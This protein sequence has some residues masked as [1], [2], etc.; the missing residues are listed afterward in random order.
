MILRLINL[1]RYRGEFKLIHTAQNWHNRRRWTSRCWCCS[2][3][4]VTLC[5][6]FTTRILN[7]MVIN[8][9]YLIISTSYRDKN[10]IFIG[11]LHRS[12]TSMVTKLIATSPIASMH[13]L[14]FVSEDEGQHIQTVYKAGQ[15]FG[16]PGSFGFNKNCYLNERSQLLTPYRKFKIV[17]EWNRYWDSSKEF[18]IEKSPAN[19]IRMRFLQEIVK[20]A[21]FI[22]IMRHPLVVA[23]ATKKW[24]DSS[25][26]SLI[27]H[28]LVIHKQLYIDKVHIKNCM[29]LKYEE[30]EAER[31]KNE[32]AVF[33]GR[34]LQIS[35]FDSLRNLQYSNVKYFNNIIVPGNVKAKYE[36]AINKYGYSFDNPGVAP[37]GHW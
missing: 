1:L 20:H 31:T 23:L 21:H 37:V 36:H 7:E 27:E 10:F 11:G 16:G 26:E 22:V 18:L 2:C 12:G 33:F 5:V 8:L 35:E 14:T 17:D 4:I 19:I 15:Y 13:T 24:N 32:L 30:L 6:V 34:D 3:Q 9:R 29:I 25:L 28:W